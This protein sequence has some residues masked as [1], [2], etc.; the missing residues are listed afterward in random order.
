[1]LVFGSARNGDKLIPTGVFWPVSQEANQVR[2]QTLSQTNKVESMEE[3]TGY[4]YLA[5]A[6]ATHIHHFKKTIRK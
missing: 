4:P 3:D 6:C 5:S 1:M 2:W